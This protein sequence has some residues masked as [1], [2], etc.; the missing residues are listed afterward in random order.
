MRLRENGITPKQRVAAEAFAETG[1]LRFAAHAAGYKYI[2]GAKQ[3]VRRPAA[4][5][6]I[7]QFREHAAAKLLPLVAQRLEDMML[8]DKSPTAVVNASNTVLKS[9]GMFQPSDQA[10]S[11]LEPHEMTREQL[12]RAASETAKI[13]EG[14]ATRIDD[15][16]APVAPEPS[17][18]D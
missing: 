8:Q 14:L 4:K 12:L 17:I 13:V 9:L 10:G 6:L 11:E 7:A 15:E 2:D 1:S 16:P 18:F 3:A 5:E